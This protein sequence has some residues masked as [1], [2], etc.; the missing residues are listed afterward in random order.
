MGTITVSTHVAAPLE[1]TF[2]VYTDLEKP[3]S[4]FPT[5]P[6]SKCSPKAPSA[7]GPAGEKRG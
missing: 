1:R 5:S 6:H 3:P 7:K 4:G 2:E